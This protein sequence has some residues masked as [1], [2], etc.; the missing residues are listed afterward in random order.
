MW[1]MP[2]SIRSAT[3]KRARCVTG[4][5]RRGESERRVVSSL[6]G[7]F[8][9]RDTDHRNDGAERF[10]AVKFHLRRYAIEH[11]RLHDRARPLCR[12]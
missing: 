11:G 4:E 2:D 7:F 5:H 10:I 9:I 6:N 12:R 8:L 1:Q 3:R